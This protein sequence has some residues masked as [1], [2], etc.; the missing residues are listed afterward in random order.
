MWKPI[1]VRRFC[2]PGPCQ[3]IACPGPI[4]GLYV[5]PRP[6]VLFSWVDSHRRWF[7]FW[8]LYVHSDLKDRF[9]FLQSAGKSGKYVLTAYW[10]SFLVAPFSWFRW[11]KYLSPHLTSLKILNVIYGLDFFYLFICKTLFPFFESYYS[12]IF[13]L[14]VVVFLI[15]D[16]QFAT[17]RDHKR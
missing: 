8:C 2:F 4:A 16:V 15:L 7:C 17:V 14:F 12:Y 1:N 10:N 6:S 13:S 9:F 3:C 11:F 5:V